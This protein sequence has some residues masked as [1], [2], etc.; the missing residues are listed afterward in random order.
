MDKI[1]LGDVIRYKKNKEK[2][3]YRV[4]RIDG[5]EIN[6]ILL[7]NGHLSRSGY[8][9]FWD[10][11]EENFE[12]VEKSSYSFTNGEE[13]ML[14]AMSYDDEMECLQ[15]KKVPA[16]ADRTKNGDVFLRFKEEYHKIPGIRLTSLLCFFG[17]DQECF[18]L[19]EDLETMRHAYI[20]KIKDNISDLQE[21][22]DEKV[23]ALFNI[24][25]NKIQERE[26]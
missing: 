22:V 26:E 4:V 13:I 8:M 17:E 1:Q 15:Y 21:K 7:K 19:P 5:N 6:T 20:N 11:N 3:L 16:I 9:L 14:C 23:S 25:V 24:S 12:I 10:V 2:T 18:G